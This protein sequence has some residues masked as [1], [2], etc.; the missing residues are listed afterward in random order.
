MK[1]DPPLFTFAQIA[2]IHFNGKRTTLD[3]AVCFL[4]AQRPAFALIT[5]DNVS[6]GRERMKTL[7]QQL[8]QILDETLEIPYFIVKGDNDARDFEE[9]W[10]PSWWSFDYGGLHFIGVAQTRDWE[11]MGIGWMGGLDWL[12]RDL[13][14]AKGKPT[15][16]LTHVPVWPPLAVSSWQLGGVL[17][18]NNHAIA[19]LGGHLHYDLSQSVAGIVHL[20]APALG[21]HSEHPVKLL[22]VYSKD[23]LARTWDVVD[24]QYVF[25]NKWQRIPLPRYKRRAFRIANF[26][27]ASGRQTRFIRW[28]EKLLQDL[29]RNLFKRSPVEIWKDMGRRIEFALHLAKP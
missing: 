7:H 24:E 12:E 2:D 20:N 26:R 6:A 15:L 14:V 4:N 18:R 19:T 3:R 10:G 27:T 11:G 28:N 21:P 9:V 13:S 23:I 16:L 17:L 25:R 8:K 1:V 22:D 5:G 29:E